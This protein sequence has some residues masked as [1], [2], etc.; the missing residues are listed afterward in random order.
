[1][2]IILLFSPHPFQGEYCHQTWRIAQ[3]SALLYRFPIVS[4][5]FAKEPPFFHSFLSS[6]LALRRLC[7]RIIVFVV[8]SFSKNLS[9]KKYLIKMHKDRANLERDGC[10][11]VFVEQQQLVL[12][13]GKGLSLIG[14]LSQL[15]LKSISNFP[16][17]HDKYKKGFS[18]LGVVHPQFFEKYILAR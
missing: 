14:E 12:G 13:I 8:V 4:A 1:M 7:P 2:N 16:Q 3:L 17:T 6:R 10:S 11:R 5:A 9:K 15:R 18:T